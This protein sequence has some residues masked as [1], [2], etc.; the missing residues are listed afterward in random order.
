MELLNTRGLICPSWAGERLWTGTA[1][2]WTQG[3][4]PTE[5]SFLRAGF[6][7]AYGSLPAQNILWSRESHPLILLRS[8]SS[9]LCSNVNG[10]QSIPLSGFWKHLRVAK[11]AEV[12]LP[13]SLCAFPTTPTQLFD[14]LHFCLAKHVAQWWCICC[15]FFNPVINQVRIIQSIFYWLCL[16]LTYRWCSTEYFSELQLLIFYA[17]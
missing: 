5:A 1:Q 17:T 8:N 14:L 16:R 10:K 3:S 4:M 15:W 6:D 7:V 11:P 9:S 12:P 2:C 13:H